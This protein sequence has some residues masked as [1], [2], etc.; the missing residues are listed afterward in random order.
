MHSHDS[1][2][3]DLNTI[4]K[5]SVND[6]ADLIGSAG[7]QEEENLAPRD[8]LSYVKGP[9][10]P[11]LLRYTIPQLLQ[12]TVSQY[13]AQSAVVFPEFGVNWSYY[14]F[15]RLVD[16]YAAGFLALGLKKGDR[17]GIWS[18][19]RPE[20]IIAQYATAR[21][22]II[23]VNINPAYRLA[24]LEH[25]LNAV[26]VKA[27]IAA[28]TF[29]TS[30]YIGML[31]ELAPELQQSTAGNPPGNLRSKRLPH[32]EICIRMGAEKT[33]GFYNF[34]DIAALA[35]PAWHRQL[36]DITAR[37]DPDDPV[38]IQ[39][40][41]GTTGSPKGATLTHY[42]IINNARYVV[43]RLN[44]KAQE[45]ICL[46][47]PLYHCFGMVM[48]SLGA[49]STGATMVFPSQGFDP[50]MTLNVLED[51]GCAAVYGVP[52]MF[53]AMLE[54]PEF[55]RFNLVSLRGGIM[56]G[57]PC[58]VEVMRRVMEE[59]NMAEVTIAYGMTET[60]PVSFQSHVDDQIEK[61]VS[62]VGRIHPH[63]EVKIIDED[64]QISAVNTAGELCTRGYSV[65]RGYWGDDEKTAQSIDSSGW[66]HTGDLA[67]IDEN[68]YCAIVGRL[69]DM[70]IRGGENIYPTEI[71]GFLFTHPKVKEAQ[72]F[73]IPDE[74]FGEEVCAWIVPNDGEALD[75]E[76]IRRF[77]QGQLAHFKIP[78]YIRFKSELPMTISGKPM[79]FVMR[80]AMIEELGL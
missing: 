18:P 65:M 24:E 71:E 70:I 25:A 17:V 55:S 11:P 46:P 74:K 35:G 64:G 21:I 10:H 20:W 6:M 12:D 36:D 1:R 32:L 42:N 19:N 5:S 7:K 23:L 52:T 16:D 34:D 56:A 61:R 78:S 44:L 41:S 38:N 27:I 2:S 14:E 33:P 31:Q 37:L 29:K 58:P 53:V 80:D 4:L 3:T 8:N 28:E 26:G 69:K 40:T 79:K 68:G 13:G 57:A 50:L 72:V 22:G 60:S 49:V 54:H 63:V 39:F 43:G 62:T 75:E 67:V 77:C 59:M 51:E 47:V 30:N 73:G 15:A 45:K 66:M 48:G 9:D 76:D